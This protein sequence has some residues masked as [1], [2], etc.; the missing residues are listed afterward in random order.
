MERWRWLPHD[1]GAF[2]VTVNIPEFMLRVVE[3]G[4]PIHTTRVVVGKPDKQTPIFSDEMEEI[5]FNPY[6]NVPNSIKIEEIAPYLGQGGG[7]FGGG[8]W[9]P[10]CCSV[11]TCA[12]DMAAATSIPTTIDW[13]RID[14]RNFDLVQPPGPDQRARPREIRVPQQ[15][16]R[17]HARHDAEIPVRQAG[18]R[19]EPW[20]HAGA[21][22]RISSP[23]I[24]LKHDK[25]WS[26]ARVE[27]TFD[28]GDDNH[29]ALDQKIPVYI[30]YFTL[31][32]N[33]DGSISTFNDIYGHDARMTAALSGKYIPDTW[34]DEVMAD[35]QDDQPW[36]GTPTNKR[37]FKPGRDID[38]TRALFGF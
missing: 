19:R 18:A 37:R 34:S 22:S 14:I 4:K 16:R 2:Y 25:G 15:A 20:L 30:T 32:V 29:V 38:F 8:G 17:L 31:R 35:N 28:A 9:T 36:A 12:S 6:W 11:T 1:L 33:D 23:L 7:F 27:S 3:D 21:K 26:Q 5:V 24:L 10:R 13:N